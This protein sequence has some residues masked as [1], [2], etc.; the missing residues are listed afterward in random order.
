MVSS[1]KN[2]VGRHSIR[3]PLYWFLGS[4]ILHRCSLYRRTRINY[5]YWNGKKEQILL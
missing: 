1:Y 4:Q 3:D 5:V 2:Q